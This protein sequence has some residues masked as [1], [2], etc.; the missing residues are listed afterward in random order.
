MSKVYV[1]EILSAYQTNPIIMG[2]FNNEKDCVFNMYKLYFKILDGEFDELKYDTIQV[3]YTIYTS[4]CLV[5]EDTSKTKSVYLLS[6]RRENIKIYDNE[7]REKLLDEL[8]KG[9]TDFLESLKK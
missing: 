6:E 3:S 8:E 1:I 7:T 2:V 4:N 5:F 9:K